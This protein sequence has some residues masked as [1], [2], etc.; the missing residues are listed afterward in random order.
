MFG[1]FVLLTKEMH[2]FI[3]LRKRN[4]IS[5]FCKKRTVLQESK[6]F[7]GH[8]GGVIFFF[9]HASE[10]S[11]GVIKLVKEKF[12]YEVKVHQKDEH[13]R[14]IILKGIIQG[15]LFVFVNIYS[16]NKTKDQCV[17]FE[18]I[19]KQLH[20]LELEENCEVVIGGDFNVILDA[21][22]DGTAGRQASSKRIL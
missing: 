5:P 8:S 15:H 7:G 17:F 12:D 1:G 20:E 6:I 18:E 4:L 9:S 19:Q 22:L 3:G 13:G 11:W 2:F 21:D 14:F 10:H 16:P